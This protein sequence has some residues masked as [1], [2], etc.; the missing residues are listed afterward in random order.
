MNMRN[1]RTMTGLSIMVALALC[2]CTPPNPGNAPVQQAS[3]ATGEPVDTA[4]ISGGPTYDDETLGSA[5]TMASPV[6][7]AD[8]AIEPEAPVDG[9][10]SQDVDAAAPSE[11][12]V[13]DAANPE[14]LCDPN[15][16]GACQNCHDCQ[17]I[18]SGVAK[19]AATDC[20]TSCG[21]D[22]ACASKCVKDRVGATD[23][24]TTCLTSFY[25]CLVTTCLAE[26][27]AGGSVCTDCSRNKRGA[28]GATCSDKWFACSGTE[29]N[30]NF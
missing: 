12:C 2:A 28:D 26:C 15:G 4:G 14:Y 24:C 22:K 29:R 16:A 17:Q 5:G 3:C 23:E 30:P 6:V 11:Q 21:S 19:K 25:D 1:R 20:G 8:A 7:D 18:E 13:L 9:G 27:I 10:G